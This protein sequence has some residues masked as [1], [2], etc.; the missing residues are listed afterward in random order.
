M[1]ADRGADP[2]VDVFFVFAEHRQGRVAGEVR[3]YLAAAVADLVS[4]KQ[5]GCLHGARGDDDEP[6]FDADGL[7]LATVLDC[8]RVHAG[9]SPI[10]DLERFSPGAAQDRRTELACPR[11]VRHQHRLL[12][13]G[14]ASRNAM[15]G[16]RAALDVARR[17]AGRDPKLLGALDQEPAVV[18]H[19]LGSVRVNGEVSLHALEVG[20]QGFRGKVVQP[21]FLGPVAKHLVGC[22]ETHRC[23]DDGRAT[24]ALALQDRQVDF[25]GLRTR[26]RVPSER[27]P[28]TRSK[29]CKA[30]PRGP[31]PSHRTVPSRRRS[32]RRRRRSR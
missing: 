20:R 32:P 1:R 26:F 12:T 7:R 11:K 9:N 3:A 15:A 5:K 31:R 17:R 23:I 18:V 8:H 27:A 24:D 2:C 6:A 30:R 19:L 13:V 28:G 16:E 10:V 29:G 14:L 4:L 22:P 25:H 21:M